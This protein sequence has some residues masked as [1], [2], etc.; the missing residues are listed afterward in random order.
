[1]KYFLSSNSNELIIIIGTGFHLCLVSFSLLS[2]GFN[3]AAL[4]PGPPYFSPSVPPGV[5]F[6]VF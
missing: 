5:A 4:A 6:A 1:M 2:T 3:P